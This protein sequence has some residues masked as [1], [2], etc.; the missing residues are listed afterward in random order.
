MRMSES[1]TFRNYRDVRL[2]SELS[3]KADV[4]HH[5]ESMRGGFP[6]GRKS[7]SEASVCRI[8]IAIRKIDAM[9]VDKGVLRRNDFLT[10]LSTSQGIAHA[11]PLPSNVAGYSCSSHHRNPLGSPRS[12]TS[13]TRGHGGPIGSPAQTRRRSRRS[14]NSSLGLSG[15]PRLPS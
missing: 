4:R 5:S 1:G 8:E 10:A 15:R 13:W 11:T 6:N 12:K 14:L 2:E 9:Y 7:R 3:A